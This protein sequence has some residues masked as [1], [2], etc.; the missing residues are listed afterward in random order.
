MNRMV[1][2]DI[3]RAVEML[4][5]NWSRCDRYGHSRR[6][7]VMTVKA[8]CRQGLFS[9]NRRLRMSELPDDCYLP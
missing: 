1:S 6:P 4:P 3:A 7:T 5:I 8:K 2:V 9:V